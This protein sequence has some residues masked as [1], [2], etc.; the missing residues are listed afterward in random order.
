M[1]TNSYPIK[2]SLLKT[3]ILCSSQLR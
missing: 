1:L 2:K 3:I